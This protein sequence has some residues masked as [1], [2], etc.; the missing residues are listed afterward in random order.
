MLE[1][2]LKTLCTGVPTLRRLAQV[3]FHVYLG[4]VRPLVWTDLG[5]R[6]YSKRILASASLQHLRLLYHEGAQG[7]TTSDICWV[8][9]APARVAGLQGPRTR[10]GRDKDFSARS[11]IDGLK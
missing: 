4:V 2:F 7:A 11:G 3:C 8:G 5:Q 10:Y 1:C 9:G 6:L